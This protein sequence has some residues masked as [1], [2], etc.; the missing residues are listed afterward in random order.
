MTDVIYKK[1]Y[2]EGLVGQIHY[3]RAHPADGNFSSPPIVLFHQNPK[4]SFEYRHL[5]KEMGKDHYLIAIDTPGYGESDPPP[6]PMLMPRLG[7]VMAHAMRE[8]LKKHNLSGP[9]CVF[10]YHTGSL[11]SSHL[12]INEP[13]LVSGVILTG[14]SYHDEEMAEARLA[15]QSMDMEVDEAGEYMWDRWHKIVQNR[16]EGVSVLEA[17]KSFVEDIRPLNRMKWAY[18]AAYNY[19]PREELP[20]I[21]QPI[22]IIQPHELLTDDTLQAHREAIPHAKLVE[23][24]DVVDDVFDTG[25]AEYAEAMRDWLPILTPS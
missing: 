20:K 12:A 16:A 9:V 11:I 15:T 18:H 19:R 14:L 4:S 23:Y 17:A 3:Y 5:L 2:V 21:T 10:G 22:L 25:W 1:G 24:P 6:A 8:I 13:D 7:E